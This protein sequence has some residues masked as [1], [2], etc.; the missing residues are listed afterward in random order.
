MFY[1]IIVHNDGNVVVVKGDT[2]EHCVTSTLLNINPSFEVL[3]IEKREQK[4]EVNQVFQDNSQ[5]QSFH[6]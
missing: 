4:G 6:G 1:Y 5:Q 3:S 2:C